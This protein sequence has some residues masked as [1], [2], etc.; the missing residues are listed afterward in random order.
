MADVNG[1]L[2]PDY[3]KI[4]REWRDSMRKVLSE[5]Q[6]AK[7]AWAIVNY[8]LDEEEPNLPKPAMLVFETMRGPLD[9]R[10]EKSIEQLARNRGDGHLQSS[11]ILE[12]F[13]RFLPKSWKKPAKYLIETSGTKACLA[14][15]IMYPPRDGLAVS[16]EYIV[17]VIVRAITIY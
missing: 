10:R 13:A 12:G 5:A 7:A 9:Y 2:E 16:A 1:R 8:Y 15:N 3:A 11:R 4:D 14:A 6:C 17:K